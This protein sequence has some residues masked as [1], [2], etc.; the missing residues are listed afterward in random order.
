MIKVIHFLQENSDAE[1]ETCSLSSYTCD[2]MDSDNDIDDEYIR[3]SEVSQADI[4]SIIEAMVPQ[5]PLLKD[6]ITDQI[7]LA[8]MHKLESGAK[9]Y[10]VCSWLNGLSM[11]IPTFCFIKFVIF[12]NLFKTFLFQLF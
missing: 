2:E 1:S 7:V 3:L 5:A 12:P 11:L 8:K 6:L 10:S 9:L 4:I